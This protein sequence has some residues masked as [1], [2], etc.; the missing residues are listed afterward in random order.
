MDS[1]FFGLFLKFHCF[2]PHLGGHTYRH[3]VLHRVIC[4]EMQ[5][6]AF[7]LVIMIADYGFEATFF[8]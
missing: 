1:F 8:R 5:G 7:C 4:L 6:H 3:M 2:A